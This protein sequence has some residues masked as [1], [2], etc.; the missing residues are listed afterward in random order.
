M[1]RE[2]R[3]GRRRGRKGQRRR[4]KEKEG[5]KFGKNNNLKNG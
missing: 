3:E 4:G 1:R 5:T 2:D